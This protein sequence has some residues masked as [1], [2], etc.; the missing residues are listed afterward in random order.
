[1]NYSEVREKIKS[2]DVFAW[3][4]KGWGS[5]YDIKIQIVRLFTQSEY[6]HVGVAVCWAQ[7]VF[8]LEA[9]ASGVRLHPLS[10]EVPF[11]WIPTESKW[12]YDVESFA[13]SQLGNEY[14]TWQA[15]LAFLGKLHSGADT[16][17]QCA[18]YT[19]AI[20]KRLGLELPGNAT[21]TAVVSN[22]QEMGYPVYLVNP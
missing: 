8:I 15:I 21:P 16:T 12:E 9:V 4:H 19:Q 20:L 11:Y 2:G 17:W 5:W 18:E 22:L 1:M 13:I 6:S 3:T 14:S 7:R 10:K